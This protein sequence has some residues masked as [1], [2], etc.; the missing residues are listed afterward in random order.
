MPRFSV[1]QYMKKCKQTWEESFRRKR[2]LEL[3]ETENARV[4]NEVKRSS[5]YTRAD[6]PADIIGVISVNEGRNI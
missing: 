5:N 1:G 2:N 3:M 4:E 6:N